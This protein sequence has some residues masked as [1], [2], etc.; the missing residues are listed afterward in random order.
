LTMVHPFDDRDVIA[1]QGTIG[2]EILEDCPDVASVLV[3]VGGGG[4]V[5][6]IAAAIKAIRPNVRVIGLT[7]DG[8]SAMLNSRQAGRPVNVTEVPSLADSLGGGIGLA[9][10]FS[11]R[12]VQDLVDDLVPMSEEEIAYGVKLGFRLGYVLEGG[13]AIGLAALALGKVAQAGPTV[14]VLSG[15]RIAPERLTSILHTRP[16]AR[17]AVESRDGESVP[18]RR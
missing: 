17:T 6:G 7:L 8:S 11:F 4:L 1:G 18:P 13:G 10:S 9:N 12:L 16:P 5:G 2:L 14:V 15:C 3:P